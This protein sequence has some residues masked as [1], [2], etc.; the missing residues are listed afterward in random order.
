MFIDAL[1]DVDGLYLLGTQETTNVN[2]ITLIKFSKST[3]L[4]SSSHRRDNDIHLSNCL[5]L[6]YSILKQYRNG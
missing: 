6:M 1:A 3:I 5:L 2:I 4:L